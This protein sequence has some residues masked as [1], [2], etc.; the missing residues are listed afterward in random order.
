M[1]V[2]SEPRRIISL[3]PSQTE[4]LFYL[5]L[6]REIVGVTKFC[7]HPAES[8]RTKT[9]VGGTK[10]FRFD[11]IERL[12][13]DLILGNKEENYREGI[14]ALREKYP[15]WISDIFT[16]PDAM[17]MITEVGKLTGKVTEAESLAGTIGKNFARLPKA[18]GQRVAYFIWQN[19][20]MVAGANTFIDDMLQRCGFTNV[21]ASRPRYPQI[22][23]ADLLAARPEYIF[24]SS[25]PYP[26]REKHRVRF[27]QLC[28]DA[29]VRLVDGEMFSW[30]GSRLLLATDYLNTL[31]QSIDGR[32]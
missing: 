26:F 5:G 9:R 29:D 20:L 8:V 4:L 3:V 23:E 24:L 28:P 31:I 32:K 14:E 11:V 6:D 16:L 21:F 17:Q 15:V 19:P 22:T 12:Q 25:E 27:S 2:Y 30:Y 10:N 1:T 13:P 18:S 7:I